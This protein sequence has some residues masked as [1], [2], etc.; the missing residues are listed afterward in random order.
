MSAE[1]KPSDRGRQGGRVW[2]R[3]MLRKGSRVGAQE[4]EERV[5]LVKLRSAS[6][7]KA[8]CTEGLQMIFPPRKINM[9]FYFTALLRLLCISPVSLQVL[10]KKA[11][12]SVQTGASN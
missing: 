7:H 5:P 9:F 3:A 10:A 2:G 1:N 4:V 8:C 6:I 11:K 12:P